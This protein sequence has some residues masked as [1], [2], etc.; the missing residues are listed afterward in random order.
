[1]KRAA[2]SKPPPRQEEAGTSRTLAVSPGFRGAQST[3]H[4]STADRAGT[5][6]GRRIR[7]LTW[8]HGGTAP[9]LQPRLCRTTTAKPM[10]N[11]PRV[12]LSPHPGAMALRLLHR[13][14]T[15]VWNGVAPGRR[16]VPFGSEGVKPGIGLAP[17]GGG[18]RATLFHCGALLRLDELG[19]LS[20][21]DRIS[22]VSG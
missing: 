15:E 7:A 12:R 5:V 18:F 2:D 19:V 20:R 8:R 1:G 11:P 4:P 6:R 14:S 10:P 16:R 13:A 22:S 3:G 21:V 9:R 17:S